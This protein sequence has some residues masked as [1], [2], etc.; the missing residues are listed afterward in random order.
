[1][2]MEP[3][4]TLDEA[5]AIVA[6]KT[7]PRVTEDSIRAKIFRVDYHK[8]PP[9]NLGGEGLGVMCYITLLNGFVVYGYSAPAS[10]ENFDVEVGRRYAYD[11]A[12]KQLWQFEGY[13]LRETLQQKAAR[14][15]AAEREADA[16]EG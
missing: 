13:L 4:I 12:F 1:M 6:T 9:Y 2:S 14:V 10:P 11:N 7:A 15:D 8:A 3:T 5:K 16:R